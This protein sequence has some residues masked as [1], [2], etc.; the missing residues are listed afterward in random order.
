MDTIEIQK[1]WRMLTAPTTGKLEVLRI[2]SICKPDLNIGL[3]DRGNRC[4]ILNLEKT[5][6]SE[7][8]GEE[9]QNIK[10]YF[11]EKNHCIVLEL[12]DDYYNPFYN[13][14]IISLYFKIKDLSDTS[15]STSTFISTINDWSSFLDRIKKTGLSGDDVRGLF[16][17]MKVLIDLINGENS[18]SINEILKGWTGPFDKHYDFSFKDLNIEVKTKNLDSNDVKISS[19]YQLDTELGKRMFLNVISVKSESD[20]GKSLE[21]LATEIRKLISSKTGDESIFLLALSQKG[22]Q[23]TNIGDYNHFKFNAIKSETY[24]CDHIEDDLVFPRLVDSQLVENIK[25][26]K[27]VIN[28]HQLDKFINNTISY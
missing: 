19:S 22:L 21:D 8:I 23:T 12:L 18:Y 25:N 2:D 14:L 26:L 10:T 3:N 4:V 27:Y 17:E 11:D 24:D 7:F 5:F 28:L 9:K 16:G 1:K 6:N 13:D 20:S 15:L